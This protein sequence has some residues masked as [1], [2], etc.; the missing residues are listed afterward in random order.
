MIRKEK[1]RHNIFELLSELKDTLEKEKDIIFAYI[2]GSYGR[3]FQNKLSDV[4]IGLFLEGKGDFFERR[5][6]L[7]SLISRVLK[8]SEIDEKKRINFLKKI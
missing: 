2:F 7:I 8:T 3:G 1:V 5:L 4:D 6:E